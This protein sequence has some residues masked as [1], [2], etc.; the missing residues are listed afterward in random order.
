MGIE[1]QTRRVIARF[2]RTAAFP[3]QPKEGP[4]TPPGASQKRDIPKDHPYD[5]K[6]LKPLSK[7]LFAASVALGHTLSA[8][9]H[10][11]QLKST[12]V[13]PDGKIGGKGYVMDMAEIRRKL[14][15]AS[16]ALSAVS[17]A[18]HDEINAP[19]WQPKL[20]LLDENDA[21]D[22]SRFVEEAEQV[23]DNPEEEAEEHVESI[24]KE[25]DDASGSELPGGGGDAQSEAKLNDQPGVGKQA[26]L[27]MAATLM[28]FGAL[29]R[30]VT[31]EEAVAFY[32]ENESWK[33]QVLQ[34]VRER[35]AGLDA[36]T[37][38]PRVDDRDPGAGEGPFNSFNPVDDATG[39]SWGYSGGV[40]NGEYDYPSDWD[41]D[42]HQ[43]S[44]E[45][46]GSA[47]PYDPN[48]PTE[49]RDFGIGFGAH[50][51]AEENLG[52]WSPHSGLPGIPWQSVGDTTPAIDGRLNERHAIESLPG[53]VAEPVA[54][55][56]YYRGDKG[57][58]V[59]T[60]EAAP[61]ETD[62]SMMDTQYVH[63][64]LDTTWLPK[65]EPGLT[66]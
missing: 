27:K 24:E 1:E 17:D 37:G 29:E 5:P 26:R 20:A 51:Q 16:E 41:N 57:N 38:G 23:L 40:G 9:R 49:G 6:A 11:S 66:R 19:H 43:A 54:R 28:N 15:E 58:L 31:P 3:F 22:V 34:Q 50:G 47:L 62:L 33:E 55:M 13:S 48:T 65:G 30:T 4:S 35:S 45:W 61:S 36:Q 56:D 42:L 14:W 12:T 21:E 8:Y 7:A 52:D 53:D 44:L 59:Q 32:R 10:F 63:E 39:D 64:D 46:A 25:N 18:I 60:A 2:Q